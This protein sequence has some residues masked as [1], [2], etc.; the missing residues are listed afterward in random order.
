MV[1]VESYLKN[2]YGRPAPLAGNNELL[3][4]GQKTS[5]SH[6]P[7]DFKLCK[8]NSEQKK[9]MTSKNLIVFT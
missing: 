5:A 4:N 6:V 9:I 8:T 7:T 2:H 3:R 1:A